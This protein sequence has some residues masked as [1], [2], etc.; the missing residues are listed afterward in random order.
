MP[1]GLRDAPVA[2]KYVRPDARLKAC[3]RLVSGCENLPD[4]ATPSGSQGCDA[5]TIE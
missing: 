3:G 1:H 4:E 5:I 2:G